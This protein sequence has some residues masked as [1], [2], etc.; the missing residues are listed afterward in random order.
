MTANRPHVTIDV[1]A[2][3]A[4]PAGAGI[5]VLRVVEALAATGADAEPAV[6]LRTG[7]VVDS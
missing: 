4:Q 2:V 6:N 5:Y 1:S 3:P 7:E